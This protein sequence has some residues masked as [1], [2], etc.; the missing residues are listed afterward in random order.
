MDLNI[1]LSTI[2]SATAALVAIIG[3]FLVSRVISLSSE[4]SS[5]Q[6]KLREINNEIYAK[7]NILNDVV[8]YL[9]EDDVEDFI[10][11]NCEKIIFEDKT[12]EQII[13]EDDYTSLTVEELKPY[14]EELNSIRDEVLDIIESQK[15]DSFSSDFDELIEGDSQCLKKPNRKECYETIYSAIFNHTQMKQPR[16]FSNWALSLSPPMLKNIPLL[17]SA[18]NQ[19]YREKIKERDQLNNE[20]AVL[21]IQKR[22]Q[23][24]ILGDYGTPRGLWSG[25][26]VLIYAC[27]VGI[28]CPSILLPYTIGVYDDLSTKYL[29]LG[30]FFSE[31]IVLFIYLAF[32]MYK[33]T[34]T[35][36]KP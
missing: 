34:Q 33:L 24:K 27:I 36:R 23:E 12:L 9:L 18:N 11:D 35:Q 32:T 20:L 3:G 17:N 30:L 25:L 7:E 10:K 31:L 6:R 5:I 8:K 1:L 22:E 26:L 4:Q 21:N 13:K 19:D 28:I 29:L 14:I 15:R 2:I 16:D